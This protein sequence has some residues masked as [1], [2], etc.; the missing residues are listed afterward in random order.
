MI[1]RRPRSLFGTL[2]CRPDF[3]LYSRARS[4][5]F[6]SGIEVCPPR[7]KRLT[8]AH[9]GERHCEREVGEAGLSKTLNKCND[10]FL[11]ECLASEAE[12]FLMLAAGF[13]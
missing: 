7:R 6:V 1:V 2:N 5:L 3:L 4:M 13:V 11:L 12:G 8:A 9:P 10:L